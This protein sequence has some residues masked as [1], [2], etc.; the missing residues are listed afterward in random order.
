MTS[1][2]YLLLLCCTL[3]TTGPIATSARAADT[4]GNGARRTHARQRVQSR[5]EEL[6]LTRDQKE[7]LA[8]ILRAEREKFA[9][10][11]ADGSLTTHDRARKIRALREEISPRI[12][13]ILT[14]EQYARWQE[15]GAQEGRGARERLL[16]PQN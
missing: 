1:S 6:G 16:P 2:T 12:K 4:D 11:Q 9:A 13:A 3:A 10:V 14:P 5:L 8:P 7:K 15:S